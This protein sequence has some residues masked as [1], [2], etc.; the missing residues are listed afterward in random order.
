MPTLNGAV[1]DAT[2]LQTG[3]NNQGLGALGW[4]ELVIM[5]AI[6]QTLTISYKNI[7]IYSDMIALAPIDAGRLV[8]G[9]R[10]GGANSN[11]H[12]DNIY[13]IG[14][15]T[16]PMPTPATLALFGLG[17]AGLGWSRRKKA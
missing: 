3:P 10:T 15:S 8:I 16:T 2:S 12:L 4:A 5:L 17:L 1:D 14:N 13:F 11:H 7:L 6:D 9:S